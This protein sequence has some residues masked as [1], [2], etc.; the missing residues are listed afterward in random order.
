MCFRGTGKI[1]LRGILP[2]P[3]ASLVPLRGTPWPLGSSPFRFSIFLR[4]NILMLRRSELRSL[5]YRRRARR[6]ERARKIFWRVF[7]GAALPV[8]LFFGASG[9]SFYAPFQIEKVVVV[10][11]RSSARGTELRVQAGVARAFA[12]EGARLFSFTNK[13]LYPR[14]SL[15][16]YVASSSP[17]VASAAAWRGGGIVVIAV[18]E[19]APF[20]EWC[21][22]T[23]SGQ[24][25]AKDICVFVDETGFSFQKA[26]GD[27]LPENTPIF[28]GGEPKSGEHFIAPNQFAELRDAFAAA[29]R[30]GLSV[31]E[32]AH[33]EAN[34]FSITLADGAEARFVLS[35]E[36]AALFLELPATLAAANLRIAGGS[37]SP[38]L[39]YLDLRFGD[40][41]VFKRK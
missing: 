18:S 4:Y 5:R 11:L 8:L 38:P 21:P 7:S 16:A 3:L 2:Y 22:S 35:P 27:I 24:V 26:R 19:R 1:P 34:D 39:Q 40:Q 36:A 15:A 17:R 37:V 9:F 32:V 29:A 13:L 33:G 12:L 14:S 30:V 20:A 28:F 10:G 25:L 41:V 31:K 6:Y 23:S